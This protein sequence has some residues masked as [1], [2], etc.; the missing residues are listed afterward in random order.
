[1]RKEVDHFF[2]NYGSAVRKPVKHRVEEYSAW[3]AWAQQIHQLYQDSV[4]SLLEVE[5][6]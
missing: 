6:L 2:L 5:A 3:L 1:M 4:A